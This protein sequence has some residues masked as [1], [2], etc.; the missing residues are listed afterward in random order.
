[1]KVV[2]EQTR[3]NNKKG[4]LFELKMPLMRFVQFRALYRTHDMS[5]KLCTFFTGH[6][7]LNCS[8]NTKIAVTISPKSSIAS[9]AL[10]MSSSDGLS[11]PTVSSRTLLDIGARGIMAY[12]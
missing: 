3:T 9:L 11:D 8:K 2:S 6:F 1:M 7:S 12:K 5:A 10:I 4:R